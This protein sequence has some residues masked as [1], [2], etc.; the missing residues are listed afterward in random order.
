MNSVIKGVNTT[1]DFQESDRR[2]HL[3]AFTD[4]K[5]LE[6]KGTRVITRAEGVYVWDSDGRRMLD[7]MAGLWC[8]NVG[9]GR[10]DLA[11]IAHDQMLELPYYNTFFQTTNPPATEL[12]ELLS[13]V[14]PAH[15]NHV[16]F[17]NS[18]S[19][20]NDTMLRMVRRYWDLK[21]QPGKKTII[22]R[23]NGYHGSTVAGASLGGMAYMHKQ[24]DLPIPGIAHIEQPYWYENG[25]DLSADEY[26]VIAARRLEEKIEELGVDTVAA[27]LAEPIQGAGGVIVPPETYWP[28][29][30]LICEKY[31]I[32][33]VADEVICGFGRTG[34]WF[35]SEY[36]AIKPDLM[37]IAKGLSSGYLPIGGLLVGDRVAETLIEKG[38]SSTMGLRIQDIRLPVRL[39]QLTCASCGMRKLSRLL[40][41]TPGRTC[42]SAGGNWPNTH[43]LVKYAASV[44]LEHWSWSRTRISASFSKNAATPVRCAV[45]SVSTMA[46]SCA[47]SRTA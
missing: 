31:D 8:V 46:S 40:N 7:A 25:G 6:K 14:T 10:K 32:L 23:I 35:G 5:A 27:F 3:H 30:K 20:A 43:W 18:G 1:A 24:G 4:F 42:K 33:L 29:I 39:R 21:E 38:V 34:K 47:R 12:A 28:E 11:Q 16:F 22:S 26:G 2:H 9:Y 37:P 45:I 13:E 19:E 15:L 17:T 44:L 36:Y 41:R